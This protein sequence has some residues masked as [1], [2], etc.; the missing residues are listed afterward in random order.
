[1]IRSYVCKKCGG[2]RD[3]PALVS[4]PSAKAE[5]SLGDARSH[6]ERI[7]KDISHRQDGNGASYVPDAEAFSPITRGPEAYMYDPLAARSIRSL[8]PSEIDHENPLP[9]HLQ[10][11][12]K[13]NEMAS[14]SQ[15]GDARVSPASLRE[16]QK[17]L[18]AAESRVEEL[19]GGLQ[20]AAEERHQIR[21][22]ASHSNEPE[23]ANMSLNPCCVPCTL[24]LIQ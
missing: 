13:M 20:D 7:I 16:I 17:R 6:A 3:A 12:R 19:E 4:P 21:E 23:E 9:A 24:L 14:H 11:R 5:H 1:M 15:E 2:G 22:M 10:M 18:E 8:S